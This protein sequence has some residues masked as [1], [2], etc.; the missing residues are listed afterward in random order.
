MRR[1]PSGIHPNKSTEGA[2]VFRS[3]LVSIATS[4]GIDAYNDPA[5]PD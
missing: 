3:S 2:V 4:L 1:A 5:P